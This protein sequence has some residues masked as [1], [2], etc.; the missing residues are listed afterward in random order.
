MEVL[1]TDKTE[2]WLKKKDKTL[3]VIHSFQ[4]PGSGPVY[5]DT[6]FET[7][8]WTRRAGGADMVL[9]PSLG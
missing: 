4:P 9:D 8:T 3:G 7:I 2:N 5:M 1:V 6:S